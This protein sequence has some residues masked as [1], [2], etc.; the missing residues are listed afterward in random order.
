MTSPRVTASTLITRAV[1]Y[2]FTRASQS[3]VE[4]IRI[5]RL[6]GGKPNPFHNMTTDV[7]YGDKKIGSALISGQFNYAGQNVDVGIHGDPWTVMVPS[8][9]YA[10]WLHSFEWMND[11]LAVDTKTKN[12]VIEKAAAIRTRSL[13]DSWVKHYGQ[14][15]SFSWDVGTLTP[16]LWYWLVHWEPVLSSDNASEKSAARRSCVVRQLKYLRSKYKSLRPSA[17]KLHTAAVIALGGARLTGRSEIYLNRGLDWLDDEIENQILSD[18]GHISRSPEIT[19][20]CLEILLTLDTLLADRGVEGTRTISRAI[21]RLTPI[22][23]FFKHTDGRLA[24]FN[25]GGRSNAGRI[26]AVL[27]S[28]PGEAKAFSYAHH[29]QYQRMASG[30]TVIIMDTGSTPPKGYDSEAHL[31]PLAFEMS[32]DLGCLLVNCGWHEEQSQGWRRPMRSSAAHSTL[33]LE[34]ASPGQLLPLGWKTELMGEVIQIEAGPAK[35]ACK[36]QDVGIWLESTHRGYL[37]RTGLAHRRRL[38][39]AKEGLDIRGEDSL[40]VPLGESPLSRDPKTFDL[41][42]HFH[43][44]IQVSLSQDQS[45]ALLVQRGKAGW[46]FRSDRGPLKL[47]SS[48]YLAEGHRPTK[49][50]QLVISG[51]ALSDNDGEGRTNRVR[52]SFQKLEGRRNNG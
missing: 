36:E 4:P 3:L 48:V 45:S 8:P 15:N 13:V 11:L 6:G 9:K 41:R 18:G 44:D 47:E 30:E 40:F 20:Q 49:C 16:R 24:S 19:F 21:D 46:R 14:W 27:S 51:D 10:S 29:T 33:T 35:A 1:S 23:A 34:E 50:Q 7:R 25:G 5:M 22:V 39:M 2:Q 31:A 52:W 42:F 43:P 37:K 17:L 12:K 32:T 28:S 38:F 26:Q